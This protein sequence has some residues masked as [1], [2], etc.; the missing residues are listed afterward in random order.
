MTV[1]EVKAILL[2]HQCSISGNDFPI[3]VHGKDAQWLS[4]FGNKVQHVTE[5][6]S[7]KY[8]LLTRH[9]KMGVAAIANKYS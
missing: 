5:P 2:Y 7:E 6:Q 1:E 9:Q 3:K 4:Q 8:E